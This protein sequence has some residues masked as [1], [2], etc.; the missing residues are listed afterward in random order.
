MV[1]S[2]CSS[3]SETNPTGANPSKEYDRMK[4][5]KAFDDTKAGVKGLVDAGVTKI[6]RIFLRQPT[7]IDHEKLNNDSL[8]SQMRIPTIDLGG[9]NLYHAEHRKLIIDQVRDASE[10]WGFFQVVNHGVPINV[11]DEIIEQV[12]VFHE[13]P[14]EAKAMYYDSDYGKS[15]SAYLSNF[16]LFQAPSANWR[17]SYFCRIAPDLVDPE[18]VPIVLRDIL[19]E[20]SKYVSVLGSQLLE[21]LSEGLGLN[22]SYLKDLDCDKGQHIVCHYYP[23][24]PQP[25]LTM[26]TTEHS[27]PDFLTIL[28]Q[29]HNAS[30]L[31]VLHQNQWV[32][33]PPSR[34]SF[35]VNIGDLLQIASN[36]RFKSVEHR[37]LSNYKVPRASVAYFF[38][39][40]GESK[41]KPINELLSDTNSPLYRE[42]TV[43]EYVKH[44]ISKG[45]GSPTLS[46]FKL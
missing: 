5:L 18:A 30:G 41:C 23:E 34:G 16:D 9:K 26:G 43:D 8:K 39:T 32:D 19:M 20:Y 10:N 14:C 37:V 40:V 46:H 17:D 44:F 36:D 2:D 21:L 28:L 4:E 6:P 38:R 11:M 35:I 3:E 13:Q 33:V 12:R 1:I 45:L 25:E 7:S 24:C 27:D 31:Q 15:K 29:D 42:F 22:Q